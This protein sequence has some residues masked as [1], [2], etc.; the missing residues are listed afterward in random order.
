M[1]LIED[2]MN[3]RTSKY[4][5]RREILKFKNKFYNFLH[6]PVRKSRAEIVFIRLHT[7]VEAA[8]EYIFFSNFRMV[9]VVRIW[10]RMIRVSMFLCTD[11]FPLLKLIHILINL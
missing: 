6:T 5:I 9:H 1:Q 8:S 11:Y 10:M 4:T 3:E 2:D 7:L